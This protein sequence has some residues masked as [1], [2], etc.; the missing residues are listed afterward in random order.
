[1]LRDA[2]KLRSMNWIFLD[3]PVE[4]GQE[5]R[6]TRGAKAKGEDR[7]GG[8]ARGQPALFPTL[9]ASE[10]S[11]DLKGSSLRRRSDVNCMLLRGLNPPPAPPRG[12]VDG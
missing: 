10:A 9:S 11:L 2:A 4:T 8:S 7:P 6:E 3:L 1:M 12:C 5:R